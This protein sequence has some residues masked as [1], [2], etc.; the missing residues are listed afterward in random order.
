MEVCVV[1]FRNYTVGWMHVVEGAWEECL[2]GAWEC[3]VQQNLMVEIHL[4][5]HHHRVVH[6]EGLCV[7]EEHYA[8]NLKY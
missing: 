1:V 6:V 5:L 4:V 3:L 8:E 7:L 2:H